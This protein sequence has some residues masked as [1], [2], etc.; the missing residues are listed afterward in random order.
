MMFIMNFFL[1]FG[2]NFEGT[3]YVFVSLMIK[4]DPSV[5]QKYWPSFYKK[6]IKRPIHLK[7]TINPMSM[8]YLGKWACFL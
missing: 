3:F 5:V 8:K 6:A 7:G 1:I 2:L 4:C